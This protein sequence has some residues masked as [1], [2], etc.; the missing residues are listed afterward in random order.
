[1]RGR[2]EFVMKIA[3]M[4]FVPFILLVSEIFIFG[5]SIKNCFLEDFELKNTTIPL[6]KEAEKTTAD[7]TVTITI[8]FLDTLRKVSKYLFGNNSNLWMSQIVTEPVLLNNIR[9]LS[10]NIIRFPGGNISNVYFWD[11]EVNQPPEDVPDS[12]FDSNGNKVLAN[13]WWY[14]KNDADNTISLDNYYNML[15]KTGNS[16][17][18]CVNFSYSRYGTGPNPVATAA[19]YAAE[20]VRHDNGKT[21]FWEIGNED[22]GP[23]Q[24]GYKIDTNLNRDGQPEIIT[25]QIYGKH[26]NVFVDSMRK[27]AQEIGGQICIGAQLI[28]NF[29]KNSWNLPARTWNDEFFKESCDAADFF[30]VHSY[31]TNYGENSTAEVIL[32]SATTET[33]NIMSYLKQTTRKNRVQFKPIA[34]TEWNIF[35]VG[36]KQMVS[37]INGMH[38]TIVLGELAKHGFSMACRWDLV[39]GYDNGNDHG[40]FNKGDEPGVPIWNPRPDFFYMYY[41]QK[42]FG[43]HVLN[44][45]VD[46]NTNILAYPSRF[47]S[48]HAGIIVVNKE[49]TDQV[50]KIEPQV[51]TLGE[52]YYLYSLTGGDD[53]GEFSQSVYVNN[54]APTNATGGPINNLQ[55]I[56]AWAYTI[57]DEIIFSS[58]SR[59]VQ[60]ILLETQTEHIKH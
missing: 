25:G 51:L 57:D 22:F 13:F 31:F 10:P 24:T 20:W 38:A 27:A 34:L 41:F 9:L 12:L 33:S 6:Y 55:E 4:I 45:S 39:N 14:G 23:W 58:P 60:F 26:F 28:E 36:S 46:G 43:D 7:P 21:K 29:K 59:S 56:P 32:N 15:N 50:V 42:F 47:N 52:K 18:I 1:L 49:K 2:L 19:H 8:N 5:Q 17:L 40:M 11:A 37:F 30:I 48:E 16:G 44:A 54:E 35:A 53:N 3:A